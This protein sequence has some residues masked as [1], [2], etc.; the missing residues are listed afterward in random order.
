M[1][2]WVP[3][4]LLLGLAWLV[5][6]PLMLVALD[7]VRVNGEWTVQAVRA[8]FVEPNEWRAAWNSLWLALASVVLA[9]VLGTALA[10]LTRLVHFPGRRIVGNG[11]D[12]RDRLLR[13]RREP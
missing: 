1:K 5:L 13:H 7:A 10:L 9:G 12:F 11:F 3:L 2:R 4:L 8:F 6:E